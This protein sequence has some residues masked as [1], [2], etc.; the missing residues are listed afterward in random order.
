MHNG[1]IPE[2]VGNKL[3]K[4][5]GSTEGD[6]VDVGSLADTAEEVK[7]EGTSEDWGTFTAFGN[8][9]RFRTGDEPMVAFEM[10]G[11]GRWRGVTLVLQK[12]SGTTLPIW[13]FANGTLGVVTDAGWVIAA[14]ALFSLLNRETSS[15]TSGTGDFYG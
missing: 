4:T 8:R 5:V 14:A 1:Y 13:D 11:L 12:V 6:A 10:P 7:G 2:L 9:A 15:L 3:L